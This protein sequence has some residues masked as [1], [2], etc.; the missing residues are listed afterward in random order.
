M[1]DKKE[2]LKIFAEEEQ[3]MQDCIV[4]RPFEK[5]TEEVIGIISEKY[6]LLAE[7][8]F[9]HDENYILYMMKPAKNYGMYFSDF[10]K[11]LGGITPVCID[12]VQT[13]IKIC[14]NWD[15][16]EPETA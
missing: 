9:E 10:K 4:I 14:H 15:Y 12:K 3:Y 11:E 2:I 1:F 8:Y 16:I 13:D 7:D 5:S 6:P